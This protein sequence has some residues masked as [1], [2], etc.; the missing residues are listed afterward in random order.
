MEVIKTFTVDENFP[1]QYNRTMVELNE[2]NAFCMVSDYTFVS[3]AETIN[4]GMLQHLA[5]NTEQFE[6]V[7]KLEVA[8][9]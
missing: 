1:P 3:A 8:K 2:K 5:V 6:R 9:C 4:R 7:E